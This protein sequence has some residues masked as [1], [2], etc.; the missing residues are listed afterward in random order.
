[1][2]QSLSK[3]ICL[4]V[5][6]AFVA[7][8]CE[9]H[10]APITAAPAK[11]A[12]ANSPTLHVAATSTAT[13]PI[14]TNTVLPSPTGTSTPSWT[15]LPK[16]LYLFFRYDMQDGLYAL[17]ILDHQIVKVLDQYIANAIRMP[18]D[19]HII[20]LDGPERIILD[21]RNGSMT[22]AQLPKELIESYFVSFSPISND[23]V[24]V[25][26]YPGHGLP[27]N[28]D[29]S[30]LYYYLSGTHFSFRIQGS[31]PVWSPDG[32][33]IAYEQETY[34]S[35]PKSMTVPY[36]DITLLTIPCEA[37]NAEPCREKKLTHS[38]LA[39]EARKPSWSPDSKILAYE[40]S[41]TNYDGTS[42]PQ[43]IFMVAQDICTIGV[44]G[45]GF[46]RLTHTTDSFESYPL[47]S[48][49]GDALAFTVAPSHYEPSD[50]Y[51]FNIES[52][53][54]NNLTNTPDISEIPLFWWN[55]Q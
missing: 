17:S 47:W 53:E 25:A 8:S 39:G 41:A 51:L 52:K 28:G 4:I 50:L 42:A 34:A 24:W 48:P 36:A 38:S 32:K 5:S 19:R 40:C 12:Q 11:S 13:K 9:Y 23:V 20:L 3:L 43:D 6:V 22:T 16:G 7:I 26:G 33:Y 10:S 31:W 18:D 30:F 1:M 14:A 27:I 37:S 54:F 35:P 15:S 55:N 29:G 46:H 49:T 21:L 45:S 2:N 44:T